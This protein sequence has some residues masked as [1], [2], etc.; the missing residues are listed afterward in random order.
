MLLTYKSWAGLVS[1]V[2]IVLSFQAEATGQETFE[3]NFEVE[4]LAP[5]PTPFEDT[6]VRASITNYGVNVLSTFDP[7]IV[8]DNGSIVIDFNYLPP[9][10]PPGSTAFPAFFTPDEVVNLGKL[11]PGTYELIVSKQIAEDTQYSEPLYFT[12][13]PEP[14][15]VGIL[16]GS[17]AGLPL[18][19]RVA[20]RRHS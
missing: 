16:L 8:I 10:I 11:G 15:A 17:L 9:D 18:L 20:N 5:N 2:L 19:R 12:V 13:V 1:S 7:T 14:S 3:L 6:E 4:L